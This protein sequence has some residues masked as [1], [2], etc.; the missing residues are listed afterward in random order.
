[1]RSK[2][3]LT[4]NLQ[5]ELAGAAE[6]AEL[7]LHFQ[8]IVCLQRGVVTGAEALLRWKRPDGQRMAAAEFVP[9]AED[10]GLLVNIGE[11]ALRAACVY[12]RGW[13]KQGYGEFCVSVNVSSSQLQREDF[14]ERVI[15][16]LRRTELPAELL[17]IEINEAAL[18][19]HT[20]NS[21]RNL[22]MLIEQGVR[23]AIDDFGAGEASLT[24][25]T[26]LP[27]HAIKLDRGFLAG[28]DVDTSKQSMV[29]GVVSLAHSI[30]LR[31]AAGGVET[32]AML[33]QVEAE[34]CDMAQGF[35]LSRPMPAADL[36]KILRATESQGAVERVAA[37]AAS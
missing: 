11:W 16:I 21:A 29:R 24:R 32:L 14:A 2:A 36:S 17:Q 26:S 28:V 34:R 13:L 9:L 15:R 37:A 8:P 35:Y 5:Q 33:R 19:G 3:N 30:K 25:L 31:V 6:R 27:L 18:S 4:H 1:M 22:Q 10:A 23:L 20:S 12:R 7:E